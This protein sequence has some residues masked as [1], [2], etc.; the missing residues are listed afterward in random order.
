M[1]HVKKEVLVGALKQQQ[2]GRDLI[3]CQTIANYEVAISLEWIRIVERQLC[4]T[5]TLPLR[6]DLVRRAGKIVNRQAGEDP[7]RNVQS[8]RRLLA[9]VRVRCFD[10]LVVVFLVSVLR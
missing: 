4:N 3:A 1:G 9:L 6:I 10:K 2:A 8:T 5:L 7:R